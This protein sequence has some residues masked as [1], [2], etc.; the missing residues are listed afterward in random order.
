MTKNQRWIVKHFE[1]LVDRYGGKYIAVAKEKVV[2]TG[3]SPTE[4]EKKAKSLYPDEKVSVL[5][6][7][8]KEALSCIL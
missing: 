7:P 8:E 6:V 3:D 1:E 4:V 5:H 2:A